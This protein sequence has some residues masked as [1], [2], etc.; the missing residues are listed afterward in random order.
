[1]RVA[2]PCF[3]DPQSL[4]GLLATK[5][6]SQ[7]GLPSPCALFDT[8]VGKSV[9]WDSVVDIAVRNARKCGAL[10]RSAAQSFSLTI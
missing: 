9:E 5:L 8:T 10:G 7:S 6:S 3:S 4:V 2:P 1:M